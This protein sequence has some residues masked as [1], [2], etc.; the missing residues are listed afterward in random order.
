MTAKLGIKIMRHVI[1]VTFTVF[2]IALS[3]SAWASSD[4]FPG[5]PGTSNSNCHTNCI[6][7]F[8]DHN[9]LRIVA[10]D[11]EGKIFKVE[12]VALPSDAK[13]VKSSAGSNALD[14]PG[15][16]VDHQDQSSSTDDRAVESSKIY[17]K[18]D[19]AIVVVTTIKVYRGNA[20]IDIYD[21]T[22]S[23]P[24]ERLDP[25]KSQM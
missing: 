5:T 10:L 12:N 14:S 4:D 24:P 16:D 1:S 6:K 19:G 17:H 23:I 13:K 15:L 25:P 7:T 9:T 20:L 21:M 11:S 22:R 18:A 2:L 3:A 8:R